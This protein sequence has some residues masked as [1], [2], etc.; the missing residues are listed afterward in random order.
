MG[1]FLVSKE[2]V[3]NFFNVPVLRMQQGIC[4]AYQ[5]PPETLNKL[6]P[7]PLEVIAPVIIGFIQYFGGT[8]FGGPYLES[9]ISTPCKF[10]NDHR[11][12]CF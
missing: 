8:S 10:K 12:I 11:E 9:V 3:R 2:D 7:P 5:A 6:V 1:S 4:F